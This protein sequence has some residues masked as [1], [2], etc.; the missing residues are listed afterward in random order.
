MFGGNGDDTYVVDNAADVTSEASALGGVD[1]VLSS[2]TR[3]L[4]ANLE[5]LTL[6]GGDAITGAG[7]ALNNVLIGNSA[8]NTL[9][10]LDGADT[11]DGGL[12]ADTLQGGAGADAYVFSSALGAG[13]VDTI[14]N[15]SVADDVIELSTAVFTGLAAGVLD[16]A[17]FVIGS[18]AADADDR[19]I[20]DSA[21]GAL[22]FDADG[23]G[24]GAAVQFANLAAGLALTNSDFIV[25]G[26]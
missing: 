20:Y 22:W 17:A 5:N 19:I 8:A 15:F 13:N 18:A 6:T 3:N 2:I 14:V 9:F 24:V 21:T 26:P 25:A 1:T 23:D 12:G 16:A 4:T 7:N 10:G 11:L